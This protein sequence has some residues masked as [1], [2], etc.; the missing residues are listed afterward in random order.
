MQQHYTWMRAAF[1]RAWDP[2][3]TTMERE[4]RVQLLKKVCL[5]AANEDLRSVARLFDNAKWARVLEELEKD[6]KVVVES[7]SEPDGPWVDIAVFDGHHALMDA[8][9]VG[10]G[11]M[12]VERLRLYRQNGPRMW[13]ASKERR[14]GWILHTKEDRYGTH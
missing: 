14:S 7:Q 4:E 13:I 12:K 11:L 10:V 9:S 1:E 2:I 6:F 5:E 8:M 3:W